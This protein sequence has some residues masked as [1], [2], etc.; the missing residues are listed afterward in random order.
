MQ[1][2]FFTLIGNILIWIWILATLFLTKK[3]LNK[4]LKFLDFIIALTVWL[5]L[6][7]IFLWFI[8]KVA[9]NLIWWQV[10][11]SI[12]IWIFLFYILELFLHWHHCK[13]LSS[14]ECSKHNN[15]THKNWFLM[16]WWTLL[17]NSFHWIVLFWAF[18]ISTTF[19]IA[20][21]LAI[22]LH[23]IP[24]NVV[25]LI[26]NK[27]QEKFAYLAALWWIL[28]AIL[29]YPFKN[30]LLENKFYILALIAWWLLYT[31]LAD[32]FP[33]VK[34]KWNTKYKIINLSI[35]VLWI[36]LFLW[37]ETLSSLI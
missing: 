31:A 11:L 2:F 37:I 3:I 17:H 23:S 6:W 30:F 1:T 33:E 29:T 19:W 21:T 10:W 36:L 7:I 4:N 25:N 14:K 32:I 22:L 18:S 12:L 13:D 24:Q 20:T 34:E 28:W 15:E 27:H 26:M 8:P 9:D 5:L 35:I 16:F